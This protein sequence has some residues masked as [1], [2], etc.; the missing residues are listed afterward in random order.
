[1]CTVASTA[2]PMT[3]IP[4]GLAKRL[5][6]CGAL[7]VIV[8]AGF[9]FGLHLTRPSPTGETLQ[10]ALF[11]TL[12]EDGA[13]VDATVLVEDGYIVGRYEPEDGSTARYHTPFLEGEVDDIVRVAEE[14]GIPVRVEEQGIKGFFG[15]ILPFVGPIALF[16]VILACV[17]QLVGR[18]RL[19][20][21]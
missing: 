15:T 7:L 20:G 5:A 6:A 17:L 12:L 19:V 14:Q 18:Q 11:L 16:G 2:K 9:L 4:S 13:I 10:A 3:E 1:M 8:L 21:R